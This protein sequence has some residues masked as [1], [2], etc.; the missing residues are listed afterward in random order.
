[1]NID[2][3]RIILKGRCDLHRLTELGYGR[4]ETER[5]AYVFVGH[6]HRYVFRDLG[7]DIEIEIT[8]RNP[9]TKPLIPAITFSQLN[10]WVGKSIQKIS[11]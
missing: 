4:L 6:M 2:S 11:R 10:D 9:R 5:H 7:L 8:A 3:V 1:M